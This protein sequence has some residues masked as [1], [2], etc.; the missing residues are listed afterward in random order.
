MFPGLVFYLARAYG[1]A[2]FFAS[3]NKKS[4]HAHDK[5]HYHLGVCTDGMPLC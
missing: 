5:S 2:S 4:F 1:N 3:L